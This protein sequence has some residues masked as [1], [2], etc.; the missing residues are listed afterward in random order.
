MLP[1]GT[2]PDTEGS[3]DCGAGNDCEGVPVE[4][5]GPD[6]GAAFACC[7]FWLVFGF[8]NPACMGEAAGAALTGESDAVGA[9][10]V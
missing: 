8:L 6:C 10:T 2:E 9:A 3:A 7:A 1:C 5:A 4:G